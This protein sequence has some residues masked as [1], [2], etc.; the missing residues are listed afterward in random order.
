MKDRESD[1]E[2]AGFDIAGAARFLGISKRQLLALKA[3]GNIPYVPVSAQ[4]FIFRRADLL[5]WMD[6]NAVTEKPNG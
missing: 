3:S 5:A 2:P 1:V 4:R 6:R